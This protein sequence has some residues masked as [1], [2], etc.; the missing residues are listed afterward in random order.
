MDNTILKIIKEI[1]KDTSMFEESDILDYGMTKIK[2]SLIDASQLYV[3]NIYVFTY[4]IQIFDIGNLNL[5]KV[6]KTVIL[7]SSYEILS[8]LEGKRDGF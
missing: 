3:K 6:F 7:S 1:E 4:I 2:G 5:D 8:I